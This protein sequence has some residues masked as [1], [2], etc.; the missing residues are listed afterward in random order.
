MSIDV[1][2]Q[3]AKNQGVS[4]QN[5]AWARVMLQIAVVASG[6]VLVATA[7]LAWD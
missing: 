6:F 1:S 2:V 3:P 7:L 4:S 5:E